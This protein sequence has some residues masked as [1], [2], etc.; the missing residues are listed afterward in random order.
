MYVFIASVGVQAR[1]LHMLV[2]PST[3][4]QYLQSKVVFKV[5]WLYEYF[6]FVIT[7][8]SARKIIIPWNYVRFGSTFYG[9]FM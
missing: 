3:A 9:I 6:S 7:Y 2:N 1:G 5:N 4:E 8:V